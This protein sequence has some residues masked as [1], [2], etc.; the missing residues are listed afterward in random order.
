MAHK[1]E[2]LFRDLR[3]AEIEHH[4]EGTTTLHLESMTQNVL[5]IIVSIPTSELSLYVRDGE[6]IEDSLC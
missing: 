1:I 6:L 5:A 4:K 3:I 2:S